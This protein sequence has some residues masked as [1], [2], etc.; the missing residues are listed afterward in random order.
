MGKFKI[1]KLP[2]K[3][4]FLFT[5][6]EIK[7]IE[8][9]A[10]IKFSS[11]TNGNLINSKT[12]L[13]DQYIQSSFR[14]FS[15]QAS[16]SESDWKFSLHQGG[17]REELLPIEHEKELKTVLSEKIKHYLNQIYYSTETDCYNH[18][19]LWAFIMIIENKATVSWKEFK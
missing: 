18:P 2:K 8:I 17:F 11:I 10:G 16:K 7:E 6:K 12:F 14:G 4:R 19:Q 1:Q 5:L 9:F 3:F 13:A 15:I